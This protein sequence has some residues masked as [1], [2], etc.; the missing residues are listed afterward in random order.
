MEHGP[1]LI[2]LVFGAS[3]GAVYAL[4]L[5]GLIRNRRALRR[6]EREPVA[7]GENITTF[8]DRVIDRELA[9]ALLDAEGCAAID[10]IREAVARNTRRAI[11]NE[12]DHQDFQRLLERM[13]QDKLAAER[14]ALS[15]AA[16]RVR[17]E[18]PVLAS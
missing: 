1:A 16:I 13:I 15:N 10:D 3:A 5:A 11:H 17:V 12:V 8:V 9:T 6:L 2:Y 4:V 18:E 14:R 7:T